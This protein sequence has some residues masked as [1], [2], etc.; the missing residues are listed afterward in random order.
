MGF[1]APAQ[2]VA[3]ARKHHIEVRSVD[4]NHS[5]WDCTLEAC[6]S[7]WAL[8]LGLRLVSGL[9]QSSADRIVERRAETRFVSFDDFARRSRVGNL[10]LT[11]LSKADAFGSLQL[12]RRNAL[13]N[14]LPTQKVMPLFDDGKHDPE[15]IVSL[16]AASPLSEV[17]A[18]YRAVGLSLRDHPMKFLRPMLEKLRAAKASDLMILPTE[19]RLKVAGL[20]LLRQRPGTAKG[21][22]FVT[23]EDETGFANLIIRPEVWERCHQVARTATAML[24]HGRLQ[25]QGAIIHVLVTQ[26][27][28]LSPLLAD[29]DSNSRDFQ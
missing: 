2:L 9:S 23:L 22:T 16:P 21:I 10:V 12:G 25:R 26:L 4:I 3:D 20:V 13:W 1:Y 15:P 7:A 19:R 6:G 24:A 5:D 17:V 27:Q 8:R 18:D 14:S 29:L 11:K 28:D